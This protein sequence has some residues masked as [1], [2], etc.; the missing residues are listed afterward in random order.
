MEGQE[1]KKGAT[2]L[3]NMSLSTT[4]IVAMSPLNPTIYF[5]RSMFFSK[6]MTEMEV[7]EA[8][9]KEE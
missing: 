5:S 7:E 3:F 4:I 9:A 8:M 1:V 2:L 6:A